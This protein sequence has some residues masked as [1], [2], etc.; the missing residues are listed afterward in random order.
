MLT[1]LSLLAG[2]FVSEDLAC[3]TAG[4]LIERGQAGAA[5][6]IAACAIGIFV[7][8]VGLW[9]IGRVFGCAA[10]EWRWMARRLD[11]NRLQ[12]FRSWLDRHAGTAIVASRFLHGS[13]LPLYVVAGFVR[14]PVAVF[15][16][17]ALVGAVLW[18]PVLVLLT[19]RLGDVF[20]SRMS[21]VL[22]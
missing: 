18:T 15:A 1:F 12:A 17:W 4:L 8:D 13:R 11:S 19:A 3:I 22:G 14:L 10:F 20:V 5:S 9:A 6:A 16:G 7:G 2:T 21:R